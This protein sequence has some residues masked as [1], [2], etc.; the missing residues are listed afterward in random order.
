MGLGVNNGPVKLNEESEAMAWLQHR[1]E[2]SRKASE[3]SF[4][5]ERVMGRALIVWWGNASTRS[6]RADKHDSS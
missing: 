1:L 3:P 4:R 6:P 5:L 2:A